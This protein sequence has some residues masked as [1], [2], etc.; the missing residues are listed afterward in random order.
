[1]ASR[2]IEPPVPLRG[3]ALK[4]WREL[5]GAADWRTGELATLAAYCAAHGRWA[6]AEEWLADPEH[7]AVV[8]IRDDKGNIKSHGPAPQLAIGE[9]AAKEMAR[10]AKELRLVQRLK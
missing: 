6:E 1:M 9:R 2:T 5:V 10:L 8:T 3:A 4:R 7:G